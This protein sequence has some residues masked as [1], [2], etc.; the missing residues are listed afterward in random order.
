MLDIVFWAILFPDANYA[1][2]MPRFFIDCNVHAANLIWLFG[3]VALGKMV[4]VPGHA[5]SACNRTHWMHYRFIEPDTLIVLYECIL[6]L[7]F[8][9]PTVQPP[10]RPPQ[11][12]TS[13]VKTTHLQSLHVHV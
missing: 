7:L 2:S 13:A 6:L 3:E 11:P 1:I 12:C 9:L 10:P 5:V 4:L 8:P